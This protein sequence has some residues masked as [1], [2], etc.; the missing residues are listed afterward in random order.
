VT[1]KLL[2]PLL[3]LIAGALFGG[4]IN[5]VVGR[6]TTF[7]EARGIAAALRSEVESVLGM[8]K[9]RGYVEGIDAMISR[10]RENNYQPTY[11]DI[12]A[13]KVSHDYFAV[14]HSLASKIGLLGE[15]SG[16]VVGLYVLAKAIVEDLGSLQETQAELLRGEIA[17]DREGLLRFATELQELLRRALRDG[18]TVVEQLN[19]FAERR[20]LASFRNSGNMKRPATL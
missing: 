12:Y 5:A 10:L 7:K 17:L 19:D 15:L 1:D 13:V 11:Q 6:Y 14:F 2:V 9:V 18:P 8:V 20:W 4:V 16:P 3:L